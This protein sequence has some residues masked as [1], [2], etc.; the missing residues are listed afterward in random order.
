MK[1]DILSCEAFWQD[2]ETQKFLYSVWDK[3]KKYSGTQLSVL[4]HAHKSPWI[5]TVKPFIQKGY[6]TSNPI[7]KNDLIKRYYKEKLKAVSQK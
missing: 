5:E 3:Y 6:L 4:T 2:L 7:I 1:V